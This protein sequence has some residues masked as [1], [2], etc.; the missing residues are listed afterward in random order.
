VL[1]VNLADGRT[2]SFDLTDA[3]QLAAWHDQ[4]VDRAFQASVRGIS[5]L[6]DKRLTT[7]PLPKRFGAMEFTAEPVEIDG[8]VVGEQIACQADDVRVVCMVYFGAGKLTRLDIIRTG[9]PRYRP[10]G[11]WPP[12]RRSEEEGQ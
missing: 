4:Q 7:L 12:V 5:I 3:T 2:L 10:N 11:P 6:H 1:R 9:R 8:D